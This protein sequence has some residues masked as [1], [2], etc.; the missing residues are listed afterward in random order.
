[1][2]DD[3]IQPY[4]NI[5]WP[6]WVPVEEGEMELGTRVKVATF[7]R[8]TRDEMRRLASNLRDHLRRYTQSKYPCDLWVFSVARSD[9]LLGGYE[10][11]AEYHGIVANRGV[12]RRWHERRRAERRAKDTT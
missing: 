6:A 5:L 2:S 11:F 1:M 8:G 10:V 12:R 9:E 4:D 7:D 3:L